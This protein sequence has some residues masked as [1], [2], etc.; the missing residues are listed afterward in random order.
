MSRWISWS[1]MI[2]LAGIAG[3][4]VDATKGAPADVD[5]L[6]EDRPSDGFDR[7]LELRG[8]IAVGD[9]LDADFAAGYAGY[10]FNVRAGAR[11]LISAQALTAGGDTV[12]GV[13]GP[14]EG[15][16]W[17]STPRVAFNDDIAGSRAS[18]IEVTLDRA[19][20]YLIVVHDY[21]FAP[22]RFTLWLACPSGTC[23]GENA[24]CSSDAECVAVDATCCSCSAGGEQR[25]VHVSEESTAAPVCDRSRA[26]A[27]PGVFACQAERAA[28]VSRRCEMVPAPLP[29]EPGPEPEGGISESGLCGGLQEFVCAEGQ[30]CKYLDIANCGRTSAVGTCED[31]PTFCTSEHA[32]VCGCD[33]RTYSNACQANAAGVSVD[34]DGACEG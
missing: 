13:Y 27:C 32:P 17:T 16:E 6:S 4:A 2:A 8:A 12:L 15:D 11:L 33:G 7:P 5:V 9:A 25:A 22:G 28:C 14:L 21:G 29:P 20:K 30:F 26:I 23:S 19:G 3:C 31:E 1:V 24:A 34:F 18:L 10:E